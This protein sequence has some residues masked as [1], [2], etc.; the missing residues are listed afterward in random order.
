[1][2]DGPVLDLS[3]NGALRSKGTGGGAKPADHFAS[4]HPISD[5][6]VLTQASNFAIA[7]D[8]VYGDGRKWGPL[9]P[10]APAAGCYTPGQ[11]WLQDDGAGGVIL[12]AVNALGIPVQV[13]GAG[14]GG[15][16]PMDVSN[17][18]TG[19]PVQE[20][21]TTVTGFTL[22]WTTSQ[23]PTALSLAPAPGA[24][25]PLATNYVYTGLSLTSNT[26]YTV[27]ATGP[28]GID[29]GSATV[30]FQNRRWW[31][32]SATAVPNQALVQSL[33]GEFSTTRVQTKSFGSSSPQYI[34][35]AWPT[36]FGTPTFT[37]SGLV[38][39]AWV[40][41]TLASY[42]N[43]SGKTVSYDVYRSQYLQSGAVTV[44]VS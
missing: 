41:T 43:Q 4:A 3:S 16:L 21:G 30:Q 25:S 7:V 18:S 39:T 29:S 24:I 34:Y 40:K 32:K 6:G 8:R 11:F 35:F 22:S 36:S 12:Y 37:V 10:A 44:A 27:T 14:G 31:G 19:L 23:T 9:F 28:G 33:A 17:V 15:P 26:T 38:T 2:A 5:C 13:S 1:M 42:V 20:D